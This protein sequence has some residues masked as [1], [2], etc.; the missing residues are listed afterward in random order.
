MYYLPRHEKSGIP[1]KKKEKKRVVNIQ[2]KSIYGVILFKEKIKKFKI[3]YTTHF[4]KNYQINNN[5]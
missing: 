4:S 2:K 5:G 1:L 3:I